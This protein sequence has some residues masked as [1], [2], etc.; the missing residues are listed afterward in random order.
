MENVSIL[1]KIVFVFI[2]FLTVG[3]FYKA[4][5]KS[6]TFLILAL[7]WMVIQLI[8]GL[9]NFYE[10]ETTIPPRLILLVLP[11][12]VLIITLFISKRG[13]LFLNTLNISKLTLL[14]TIRIPVEIVL[15]FLFLSKT[16]PQLMTF[17]GRN[18]D[19][20]AGLSAPI[21]FY[22]GFTKN[23]IGPK[24]LI[25]WNIV[26]TGLLLNIIIIALLSAKTLFQQDAFDQPNIAV[27]YFPF[28]WLPSIIVPI[29][30]LSHLASLRKLILN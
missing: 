23:K 2:T 9:T 1:L 10:N 4:T 7:F 14:H 21:L 15:Y 25:F 13:K 17:E 6:R 20:L 26:C 30:L 8:F 29:V 19:I 12:I 24:L 18:Y 27:A 5:N 28:N 11:P 22:F 3:L 16:I